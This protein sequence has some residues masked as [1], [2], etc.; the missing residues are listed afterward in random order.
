MS[1]PIDIRDRSLH[2][3]TRSE[4]QPG[5]DGTR[6]EA[7][8]PPAFVGLLWPTGKARE[9][10]ADPPEFHDLHLD[11]IVAA[12]LSGRE[13]Y[14]LAPAYR[15]RAGDLDTVAFRHEVFRDLER[16]EIRDAVDAFSA[17]MREV[18]GHIGRRRRAHYR[19]EHA[20]WHLAA[21]ERYARAVT[22][23]RDAL[24]AASPTSRALVGVVDHLDRYAGSEAFRGLAADAGRITG[25]LTAIRFR[26]RLEAGKLSVS[27]PADEPDFG[28]DLLAAF[29]RFKQGVGREYH[30]EFTASPDLH[31][32]EDAIVERVALV[33]PAV[34]AGLAAFVAAQAEFIE[35]GV[36]RFDREAQFYLAW[37]EHTA[38]IGRLGV[39]FSLPHVSVEGG[40]LAGSGLFDLALAGAIAREHRHLVTNEVD[41]RP[42]E[43]IIVVTGPNQGGKST[44]ARMLGQLHHLAA[45]GVSVPGTGVRIDLV[46]G[47]HAL[48]ERQEV[49]EDLV[50]KLEEDLRRMRSIL[51]VI[52]PRSLVVMNET[53]SSTT[54]AD[55]GFINERVVAQ[56][57]AHG[58]WC[59]IVTFLD[60]LAG[61]GPSTVSMVSEVDPGDTARRTFRVR[62]R[63][64]DGLAY[65][66][67]V[68]EKHGLTAAQ[69]RRRLAR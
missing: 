40:E 68:A 61:R 59:V 63:P 33:Y 30:F 47:I 51:E 6:A 11:D 3:P 49:V 65:A 24:L 44:F 43:R 54:V 13:S 55:Q 31:H 10:S 26:L 7:L 39:S 22:A 14:G 21:A 36:A 25:D 27:A 42:G 58:S 32:V 67:A 37:L 23:L 69:I 53:F 38:R 57:E 8:A 9:P 48:F 60:E 5:P 18:R 46:D 45:L 15:A 2:V 4:R 1:T 50:S 28:A 41:L 20:R 66:L 52:T 17:A 16:P 29:E 56:I 62:R 35:P 64:A 12:V 34:F 19:Y